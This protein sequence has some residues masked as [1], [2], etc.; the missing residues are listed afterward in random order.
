MTRRGARIDLQAFVLL[1]ALLLLGGSAAAVAAAPATPP[2]SSAD[3]PSCRG[4]EAAGLLLVA[5]S[6]PSGD[7]APG[8]RVVDPSSGRT[9]RT[10][11]TPPVVALYP[12]SFSGHALARSKTA[13]LLVDAVAGSA[14]PVDLP[15]AVAD[16]IYPSQMLARGSAGKRWTVVGSDRLSVAF[17]LDLRSGR[18]I[19]IGELIGS[20]ELPAQF[21][22]FAAVSPD[23]AHALAWDGQHSFLITLGSKP[24]ARRLGDGRPSFGPDFSPDGK[25]IVYSRLGDSGSGSQVMTERVAGGGGGGGGGKVHE[26]DDI[27]IT[28][29][30]P[31]G[32]TLLIDH[33]KAG[34]AGSGSVSTLDLDANRERTM[35]DYAGVLSAVQFSADGRDALLDVQNGESHRIWIGDMA[36]GTATEAFSDADHVPFPGLYGDAR[37]ATL[38]PASPYVKGGIVGH[39]TGIDLQTGQLTRLL[40]RE[41]GSSYLP[42]TLSANGR[43]ALLEER[44]DDAST[45]WLLDNATGIDRSLGTAQSLGA[46]FAPDGCWVALSSTERTEDGIL[47]RLT[48]ANVGGTISTPAGAGGVTAWI[49]G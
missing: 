28:L 27:A 48:V 22:G 20:K 30:A 1:L 6:S 21:I 43:F 16:E 10:I 11:D 32:R 18:T 2:A 29:W 24:K 34:A 15:P 42:P 19:S 49:N 9:H 13:L 12:T 36:K 31:H 47:P 3:R 7:P 45:V 37:W 4:V 44:R 26:S 8:L 39:Y 33:R 41:R 40:D 35:L 14:K 17:L 5:A 23:D 25:E 46:A 38:T